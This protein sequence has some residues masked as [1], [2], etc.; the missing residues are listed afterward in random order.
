[1]VFVGDIPEGLC[2]LHDCDVPSCVNPE[3]LF[4]GTKMDNY[5][6]MIEKG[7]Q[8]YDTEAGKRWVEENP[9]KLV[10]GEASPQA[11]LTEEKVREMRRL[12]NPKKRNVSAL[13]RQFG[14]EWKTVNRV[15]R[16][17]SWKHVSDT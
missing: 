14:V 1:M 8:R 9:D 17:L 6:D 10:R 15:V 12:Y 13:A 5:L 11:K 4:A 16:R 7:R 2:V 3:H